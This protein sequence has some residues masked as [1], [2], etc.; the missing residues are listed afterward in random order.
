MLDQLV[1]GRSWS[2]E[3]PFLRRLQGADDV[4]VEGMVF[5]RTLAV[6]GSCLVVSLVVSKRGSKSHTFGL[7]AIKVEHLGFAM[8][9]PGDG[10]S[11]EHM[12]FP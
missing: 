6:D 1:L 10:M 7:F 5:L 8:V 2:Q 9:E 12:I 11:S 4:V 3:Q